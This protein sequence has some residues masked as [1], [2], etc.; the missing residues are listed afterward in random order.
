MPYVARPRGRLA[1]LGAASV[2]FSVGLSV[3]AQA[4]TQPD[5]SWGLDRIDQHGL[6]L[7][8]KYT[9]TSTGRDV[10]VF[11]VS[12]GIRTT[13]AE[14]Q[15][16]ATFGANFDTGSPDSDENG[17]G[18]HSASIIGGA[19][20]GVA[21]QVH[22]VSVKA[23]DSFGSGAVPEIVAALGYVAGKA[24]PNR[25]VVMISGSGGVSRAV[26]AAV[27]K[28]IETGVTVVVPAAPDENACHGSPSRVPQAITAGALS[29]P[30]ALLQ[31]TVLHHDVVAPYSGYG[32]C[33]DLYAP[34]DDLP[35]AWN[36]DDS[37]THTV[38]SP[39]HAAAF[40]A[41]AAAK[42]QTTEFLT[43]HQVSNRLVSNATNGLFLQPPKTSTHRILYSDPA[44]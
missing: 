41:G 18:T 3:P 25:D 14:F 37:A 1:A 13:H 31:P 36:T 38:A 20:H 22:I 39:I 44:R 5:P 26:D 42:L 35:G 15:G 28:L 17:I 23:F 12:T 21:K 7:D 33:L 4:T 27:E 10:R 8:E 16:R 6:P 32:P 40:I 2:L 9:Y 11:V 34:G 29:R 30:V 19:T 24:T 43:P